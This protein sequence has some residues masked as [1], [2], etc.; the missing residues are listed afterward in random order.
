MKILHTEASI[1]WGG[2]EIRIL[3]ESRLLAARGH[4]VHILCD[5]DSLLAARAK[6]FGFDPFL[7]KLKSKN[8][9]FIPPV[10]R[11]LKRLKPDI[12]NTH[13]SNDAWIVGLARV[14]AGGE[15]KLVRTR[16]VSA[17]VAGH[18][19]NRWLYGRAHRAVATTGSGITRHL[20]D[21]LDLETQWVRTIPTGV[22][23]RRFQPAHMPDKDFGFVIGIVATLRS[24]KGHRYLI[25]AMTDLPSSFT[26]RIVGD[27]P[28]RSALEEQVKVLGLSDRVVFVGHLPDPAKEFE[29]FDL[30]CLPSYANEGVPQALLQAS[31]AG[32]PIITTDAGGIPDLIEHRTNGIIV[33]KKSARAISRAVSDLERNRQQRTRLGQK[34]RSLVVEHH[35]MERM[36][37]RMERLFN[38]VLEHR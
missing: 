4:D 18:A 17:A 2:Q 8:L 33:E 21:R 31:A 5:P 10:A 14:L 30:F 36:G 1:G 24:W 15:S 13:S 28:Q 16:H 29:C 20:I 9:G 27:G 23:C 6:D 34:A 19:A 38:D 35:S 7:L 25:E 12:V 11:L 32:L 22:D 26:L 37:D 3:E